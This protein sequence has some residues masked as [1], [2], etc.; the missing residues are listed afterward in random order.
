M[1]LVLTFVTLLAFVMQELLPVDDDWGDHPMM[2]RAGADR[3][4]HT[5]LAFW[6]GGPGTCE[7]PTTVHPKDAGWLQQLYQYT[8][9]STAWPVLPRAAVIWRPALVVSGTNE[10][11]DEESNARRACSRAPQARARL[12]RGQ[13]Q[14]GRTTMASSS[15]SRLDQAPSATTRSGTTVIV[16]L[17]RR[18]SGTAR[19]S[20][21]C[22]RAERLPRARRAGGSVPSLGPSPPSPR[23]RSARS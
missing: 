15:R 12:S 22:A 19:R 23:R 10:R 2:W 1:R 7:L 17:P 16:L 8:T 5:S 14:S 9:C 3:A 20:G 4:A 11:P 21:C 18:P 13:A 6:P